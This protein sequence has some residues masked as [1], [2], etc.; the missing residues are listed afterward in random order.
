VVKSP[1]FANPD[2]IAKLGLQ[3]TNEDPNEF[4]FNEQFDPGRL[5][6]VQT[7]ADVAAAAKDHDPLMDD[8]IGSTANLGVF[9][10]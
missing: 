8:V 10:N 2:A 1:P 7:S 3:P 6:H 5:D 4:T 9:S